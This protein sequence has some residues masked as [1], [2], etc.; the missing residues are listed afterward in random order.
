MLHL[1]TARSRSLQ[2]SVFRFIAS[3][4]IICLTPFMIYRFANGDM[5]FAIIE[6]ILILTCITLLMYTHITKRADRAAML[7]GISVCATIAVIISFG[8]SMGIYWLYPAFFTLFWMLN[9]R[10]AV[11]LI[12]PTLLVVLYTSRSYF[13]LIELASISTTLMLSVILSYF[14][15][16]LIEKQNNQETEYKMVDSDTGVGNSFALDQRLLSAV[17]DYE[18][19]N[20][21]SAIMMLEIKDY[22]QLI[23]RHGSNAGTQMLSELAEL[24]A[25]ITRLEDE[26]FR[27]DQNTLV[28]FLYNTNHNEAEIAASR[29]NDEIHKARD[30]ELAYIDVH[31]G[32]AAIKDFDNYISW[33]NR[34]DG[35]LHEAREAYQEAREPSHHTHIGSTQSSH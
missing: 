11:T 33:L 9:K 35:K 21:S 18:T 20:I 1:L 31:Y 34:A 6:C 13:P 22:D 12:I 10:E 8:H 19:R 30:G 4:T 26:V 32:L 14:I 15:L 7:Y 27:A 2:E 5:A 3:F 28:V 16:E 17:S 29:I 25:T 23:H 24:L